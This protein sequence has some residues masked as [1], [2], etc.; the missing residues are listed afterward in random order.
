MRALEQVMNAQ[1]CNQAEALALHNPDTPEL[2]SLVELVLASDASP[3]W[4]R[5]IL[6]TV[7]R[8]QDWNNSEASCELEAAGV[9][10][11]QTPASLRDTIGVRGAAHALRPVL[12]RDTVTEGRVLRDLIDNPR[13]GVRVLRSKSL[14]GQLGR[15][16]HD[17]LVELL[18]WIE[19]A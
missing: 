15:K 1:A 11:Q 8:V 3:D 10:E 16:Q 12:G 18:D 2:D 13:C 9:L 6:A 17:R 14:R 4:K 5:R 7:Q 19:A